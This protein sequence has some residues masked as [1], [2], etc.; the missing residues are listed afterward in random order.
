MLN[1]TPEQSMFQ[2]TTREIAR[3]KIAPLAAEMDREQE[4]RTEILELFDQCGYLSMM[5]PEEYGGINADTV[6]LCLVI[7]E[8]AKVC[9]STSV[10]LTGHITGSVA[11]LRSTSEEQKQKFLAHSGRPKIFGISISE[12]GAGSDVSGIKTSTKLEGDYYRVNGTKCFVTNGGLADLYIVFIRT[13]PNRK[14]GIG[15]FLVEKDTPGFSIGKKEDKMGFRGS[16]TTDLIFEDALIPKGNILGEGSGG[17]EVVMRTM[18][19][20]RVI[21]GALALG[22]AEGAL[23]FVLNYVKERSQFGRSIAEFQGL[24]FMLA[25]MSTRVNAARLLVYSGAKMVD[26]GL[27]DVSMYSSMAKYYASDVAMYVTTNAVQLMGGNGYMRDYPVERMMRDA[28]ATQI[29]EGTN[30]IQR[31]VIAKRLL[32]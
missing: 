18:D 7:E 16:N 12:P 31:L 26:Q 8:L 32:S 19:K 9:A 24:R 22:I 21:V 3:E 11:F 6:S 25:D 30:Q 10:T 2:K 14:G 28:K 20:M 5:L 4:F 15:T 13:S 1:L 27:E 29:F 17:F 23:E